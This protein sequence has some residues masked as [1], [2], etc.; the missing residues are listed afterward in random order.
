MSREDAIKALVAALTSA[1]HDREVLT[2]ALHTATLPMNSPLH[3]QV[4]ALS[5][6]GFWMEYAGNERRRATGADKLQ[7][8]FIEGHLESQARALDKG[9]IG[10]MHHNNMAERGYHQSGR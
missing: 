4:E 5:A 7:W 9:I 1:D 10:T 6:V 8:Q 2:D 3:N